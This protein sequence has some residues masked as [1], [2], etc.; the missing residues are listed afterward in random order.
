[1]KMG[2]LNRESVLVVGLTGFAVKVLWSFSVTAF[3]VVG[4][5]SLL[6]LPSRQ[7]VRVHQPATHQQLLTGVHWLSED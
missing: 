4:A 1:M 3:G 5:V 7:S 2:K 6:L